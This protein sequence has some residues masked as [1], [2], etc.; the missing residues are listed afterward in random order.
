MDFD[1]GY[2]GEKGADNSTTSQ[3]EIKESVTNIGADGNTTTANKEGMTDLGDT[4]NGGI[5]DIKPNND[6]N[7]VSNNNTEGN[8]DIKKSNEGEDTN[9]TTSVYE[10]GTIIEA[11]GVKY[12]VDKDGNVVDKDGNIFK[13]S[14]DVKKWIDSFEANTDKDDTETGLTIESIQDAFGIQ[15]TDENDKPIEFENS[16]EGVISYFNA[17]MESAKEE[18]AEATIDTLYTKYPILESVISYYVANG[19]SLDGYGEVQDRTNIVIDPNNE[20]QHEAIIRTAWKEQGRR[21]D[22]ENY[23]QYIKAQNQLFDIANEE[24]EGIKERDKEY[25]DDIARKAE[26]AEL[27]SI[28]EQ[29]EYWKDVEDTINSRVIAGFKIPETIIITRDG[30]KTSATPKDFFNYVFQVDKQGKSAYEHALSKET[31]QQRRDN[32]LLAA[33]IKFSGGNYTSLVNMA[34]HEN[35]V[36]TIKVKSSTKPVSKTKITPPPTKTT[37]DLDFGF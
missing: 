17:V 26:E 29:K 25:L 8:E 32:E 5:E 14:V 23:I 19:N 9:N 15:I 7:P 1:F 12:V 24:L 11:D 34:I 37:K 30:Q 21:G 18:I 33:Y 31:H 13:Q 3:T 36:K 35:N 28:S 16:K 2:G 4:T 6:I 27:K 20:A 22:V 10:P